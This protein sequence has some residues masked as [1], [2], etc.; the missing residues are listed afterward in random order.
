MKLSWYLLKRFLL[1]LLAIVLISL[2]LIGT[3]LSLQLGALIAQW[4]L[5][6]LSV[7][8]INGDLWRGFSLHDLQY[9]DEQQ[10]LKLQN[11][12]GR[13]DWRC[14]THSALCLHYLKLEGAAIQIFTAQ[15]KSEANNLVTV[16][17]AP[18]PIRIDEISLHNFHLQRPQLQLQLGVLQSSLSWQQDKLALGD[19]LIRQFKAQQQPGTTNTKLKPKASVAAPQGWQLPPVPA[20]PDL[21]SI[22]LP[23]QLS[24]KSLTLDNIELLDADRPQLQLT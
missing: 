16:P 1:S 23:L 10:Q 15:E 4:Y 24:I 22:Q 7:G 2:A 21:N 19:S 8:S 17:A 6:A 18:F 13:L 20:L 5:P 11:L 3:N 9:Q 14:F 12:Q